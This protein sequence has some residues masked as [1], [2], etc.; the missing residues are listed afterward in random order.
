[1]SMVSP[2]GKMLFQIR[3]NVSYSSSSS[4]VASTKR[5]VDILFKCPHNMFLNVGVRTGIVGLLL[6]LWILFAAA[7]MC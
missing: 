6:F 5:I 3:F 4:L 1:M 7:R 2:S